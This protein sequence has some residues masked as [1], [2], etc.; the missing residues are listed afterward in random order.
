MP[1]R[2]FASGAGLSSLARSRS[3][4]AMTN[5]KVTVLSSSAWPVPHAAMTSP[6]TPGPMRRPRLKDAE[7]SDTAFASLSFGTISDTKA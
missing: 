5:T 6:A 4:A 7:L 3:R 1:P 2:A